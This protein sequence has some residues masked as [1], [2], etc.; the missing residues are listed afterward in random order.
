VNVIELDR[1]SR[2]F[3][4]KETRREVLRNVSLTVRAGEMLALVGAS[5]CGKTTLLNIV[6]A[7]DEDFAGEAKLLGRSLRSLGDDER[8]EL[9]NQSIGFVFQA[10]HLLEHLT[11]LENVFVPLWLSPARSGPDEET[12]RAKEALEKVGLADRLHD[13]VRPLS[14]GER[15]RVAIARAIVNR[16]KLLLADEPT[17]NLDRETGR[18]IYQL[19]E[20]IKSTPCAVMVATHDVTLAEAADRTLRLVD[21]EL[22]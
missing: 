14:G 22:T 10:F 13:S 11:L 15:Q 12:K 7:L 16:P 2:T 1:V 6:G 20:S 4:D 21:G 9:R 18:S 8:T 3:G 19:F 17:G 5:G